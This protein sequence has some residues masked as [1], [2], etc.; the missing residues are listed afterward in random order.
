M[1]TVLRP[2]APPREDI[3]E[4]AFQDVVVQLAKV[5]GWATYHTFDSRRSDAGFPDLVLVRE[6]LLFRE[7]KA[8]RGRMTE[9]QQEWGRL[10]L[11]A[12]ANWAVWRPEDFESLIVP[13]L[14]APVRS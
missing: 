12:G 10:L 6:R 14:T 7:L 2:P 9:E 11:H 5:C 8:R 4:A 13:T 3:T 1:T